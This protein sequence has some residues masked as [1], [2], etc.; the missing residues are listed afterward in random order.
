MRILS[1]FAL[2]FFLIAAAPVL[3]GMGVNA[4][5]TSQAPSRETVLVK[6]APDGTWPFASKD[7]AQSETSSSWI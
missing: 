4:D 6:T 2:S 1:T 7:S 5:L 3:V